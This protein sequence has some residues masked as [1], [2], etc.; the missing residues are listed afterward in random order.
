MPPP[1]F[2]NVPFLPTFLLYSWQHCR[3]DPEWHELKVAAGRM[4]VA[5][6][7]ALGHPHYGRHPGR[8]R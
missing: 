8:V 7:G 1:R 2:I 5:T 6:T 4:T 3:I